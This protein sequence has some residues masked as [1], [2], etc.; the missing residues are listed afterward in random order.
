MVEYSNENRGV[1]FTNENKTNEKAPDYTGKINVDGVDKD[2]AGWIKTSA[3]GKKFLSLKV[4]VP[5]VKNKQFT[6]G[7]SHYNDEP[8]F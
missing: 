8:P 6:P 4:N 2:L 1:L 5:Y 7:K 3:K